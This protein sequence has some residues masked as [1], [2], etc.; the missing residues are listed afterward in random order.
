MPRSSHLE[1]QGQGLLLAAH[2]RRAQP[3]YREAA[4]AVLV[5]SDLVGLRGDVQQVN[6]GLV[7]DLGDLKGAFWGAWG[8]AFW[9]EW[10][11]ASAGSK[12]CGAD[13]GCDPSRQPPH[14]SR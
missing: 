10:G 3:R 12:L 13:N 8:S 6:N 11:R 2:V 7:V 14:T 9:C 1:K 4:G 5:Q